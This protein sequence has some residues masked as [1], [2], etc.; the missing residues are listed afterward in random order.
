V[1]IGDG[2]GCDLCR[3]QGINDLCIRYGLV[4]VLVRRWSGLS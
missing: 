4:F 2:N 3:D 1:M